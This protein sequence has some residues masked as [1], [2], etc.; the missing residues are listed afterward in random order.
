M[1][2]DKVV[3]WVK[4]GLNHDDV[5]LEWSL[6]TKVRNYSFVIYFFPKK[7][8][9]KDSEFFCITQPDSCQYPFIN[10]LWFFIGELKSHRDMLVS[11]SFSKFFR[12]DLAQN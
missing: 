10:Y 8:C 1:N 5:I 12:L 11:Q 3:G 9:P 6:V 7:A 4:K 2:D